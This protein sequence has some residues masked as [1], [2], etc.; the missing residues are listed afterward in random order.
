MDTGFCRHGTGKRK[1]ETFSYWHNS[2][3]EK[4]ERPP[5]DRSMLNLN[6]AVKKTAIVIAIFVFIGI[7]CGDK[8]RQR[9]KVA[10]WLF[11]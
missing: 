10:F 11:F 4:T 5:M 1:G 8:S 3:A 6:I 9:K 7:M 2:H